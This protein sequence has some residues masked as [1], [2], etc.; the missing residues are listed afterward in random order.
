MTWIPVQTSV[1]F[2]QLPTS[3]SSKTANFTRL[4]L[5]LN[6]ISIQ[7]SFNFLRWHLSLLTPGSKTA[8]VTKVLLYLVVTTTFIAFLCPF[9]FTQVNDSWLGNDLELDFYANLV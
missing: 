5:I 8:N 4:L 7:I 6:W 9:V 2:W 3:F 1:L